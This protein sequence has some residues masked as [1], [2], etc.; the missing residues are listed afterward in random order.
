MC[1]ALC[2]HA[3]ASA[4]TFQFQLVPC[5]TVGLQQGKV[6]RAPSH[7]NIFGS[8]GHSLA[9]EAL[10]LCCIL[11]IHVRLVC[12]EFGGDNAL[13]CLHAHSPAAVENGDGFR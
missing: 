11:A 6:L 4:L 2:V 9:R 13:R 8:V 3:L 7:G 1:T 5:S 12:H 10:Q